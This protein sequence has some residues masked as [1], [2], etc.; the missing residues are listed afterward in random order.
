M[1]LLN[2]LYHLC[3]HLHRLTKLEY[4]IRLLELLLE[5]IGGKIVSDEIGLVAF[6][7][8]LV[9]ARHVLRSNQLPHHLETVLVALIDFSELVHAEALAV[10][11]DFVEGAVGAHLLHQLDFLIVPNH[12]TL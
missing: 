8:F 4:L 9:N 6:G 5:K 12:H 10:L 1:N 7:E 11:L 2:Q 3:K